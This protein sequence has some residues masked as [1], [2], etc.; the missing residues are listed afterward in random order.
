MNMGIFEDLE[1]R[2]LVKQTTNTEKI[3]H[4]LNN[5][6][7]TFYIGFDPTADSLHVGH[8]LQVVTAKRLALAGHKAVM[9]IGGA[10]ATIGDPSGKT[11]MRPML[12][13]ETIHHN[14]VALQFQIL[15]VMKPIHDFVTTN[16]LSWFEDMSLMKFLSEV[17]PHFS[18]NNM[19]RAE[20][21]KARLETGL[22][23]L[24]FN[25][26]LFQAF[27]FFKLHLKH[28]C[29]LQLGGDDQWSN[30]LAGIDLTHKLTGTEVFGLTIPLLLNSD[31]TKMGKT[32]KGAVW[33][34]KNKTSV[35][36]FFQF[37]RNIPDTELEKCINQ[38]TFLPPV[39]LD[40]PPAITLNNLKKQLAFELTKLV[41]GEDEAKAALAKAEALFE[42]Q[43]TS[44]L[45]P[46]L[47]EEGAQ[48]LD[49]LVK[50]SFAKSRTDAR[51][52]INNKGITVND[53]VVQNPLLLL[54]KELGQEIL[55]R[56]GKKSF[57]RFRFKENHEQ[58]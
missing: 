7:I 58:T 29:M 22:S 56:K 52:L 4:L 26:M 57:G 15:G 33:L 13:K 25:Y 3:R 14:N 16:N 38:L 43:D 2:G 54:T 21:F 50:N 30:I 1:K 11:S 47:I 42:S 48:L 55:I 37:W 45:E 31:G 41:H 12:D 36:D 19:L 44:S 39:S 27:D 9:L 18:V 40:N 5:E 35:F 34:D 20:C 53:Q 24:E 6:Q 8:L 49:V 23:F 17:A 10:T 46:I 51:N 28:R 32:E